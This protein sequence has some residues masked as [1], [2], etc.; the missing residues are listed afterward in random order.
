MKKLSLILFLLFTQVALS[1]SNPKAVIK[2]S[3]GNFT[4]R[5]FYDKTPKTVMNFI[6][7]SQSHFYDG[8]IFHRVI[9]GFMIQTG[10]PTGTGR[11]GPGYTFPDEF[12]KDLRHEKKGIVSMANR[13]PDTNG[14]QFFILT[15]KAHHLD[16]KHTVFG[17]VI[18]GFNVC[19]KISNLKV[20]RRHLPEK[21]VTIISIK[22]KGVD[23]ILKQ[24]KS[25]DSLQTVAE[26]KNLTEDAK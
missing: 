24:E 15:A 21:T 12:H 4:I 9:K 22:I 18:K 11:G 10:D 13:G 3:M 20:D 16:N 5:L 1:E 8:V 17:E 19:K 6:K 7:L 2:T 25:E 23:S 26:L 14:S